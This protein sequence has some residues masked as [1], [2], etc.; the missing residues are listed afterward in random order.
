MVNLRA[1]LAMAAQQGAISDASAELVAVSVKSRFYPERDKRT[2]LE[3]ARALLAPG[4]ASALSSWIAENGIINRKLADAEALLRRIAADA[5]T[6]AF[7]SG[8]RGQVEFRHTN[9][10]QAL[11]EQVTASSA[12][13]PPAPPPVTHERPP[14]A[15][16]HDASHSNGD[17]PTRSTLQA[18]MNDLRSSNPEL[19][20]RVWQVA[21]NRAFALS[22]AHN[23]DFTPDPAHVQKEADDFRKRLELLTPSQTELWLTNNDLTVPGFSALINDSVVSREMESRLAHAVESQLPNA[24]RVLGAYAPLRRARAG[25][26]QQIEPSAPIRSTD[27][28]SPPSRSQLSE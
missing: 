19:Y 5:R 2:M 17:E 9:A 4:E 24:L 26:D 27:G 11:W 23:Q 13:P 16:T 3:A 25:S 12:R 6:G 14:I 8:A 18:V 22:L 21:R 20:E 10:W 15:A 1:T 28:V 7:P